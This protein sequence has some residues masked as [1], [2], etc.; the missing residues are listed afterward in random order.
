MSALRDFRIG[1]VVLF[2]RNH[3]FWMSVG[4]GICL[5]FAVFS[6]SVRGAEVHHVGSFSVDSA[7]PNNNKF[8]VES[9]GSG[10]CATNPNFCKLSFRVPI[11]FKSSRVIEAYDVDYRQGVTFKVPA[12]WRSFTLTHVASGDTTDA[13]ISIKGFGSTYVLSNTVFELTGNYTHNY[14]WGFAFTYAA[15]PCTSPGLGYWSPYAY[16]FFWYT[17]VEAHCSTMSL[18]RIPSLRYEY[19]DIA[20]DVITPAPLAMRDGI[21]TGRVVYSVGPFKDFDMGDVMLPSDDQIVFNF[22][23]TVNHVLKVEMPPGGN[24]VELIPVGGWHKWLNTGRKPQRLFR[25]QIFN[26][27]SSTKFKMQLEC[28]AGQVGDTCVLRN[29]SGDQVPLDVLVSLPSG[30]TGVNG[31]MVNRLPLRAGASEV[32]QPYNYVHRTPAILHFEVQ[33][34]GVQDMLRSDALTWYGTVS[35]IWDSEI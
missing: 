21:Y 29:D 31:G 33:K 24:R 25:D 13:Q 32:F 9:Q 26:I 18:V 14:L 4:R 15:R 11:G 30:F 1:G 27:S 5:F 16:S 19:M 10:F 28:P 12:S 7:K 35:V 6:F 22:T 23:F 8:N 17:P 34:Q 3:K 20:Y 2:L